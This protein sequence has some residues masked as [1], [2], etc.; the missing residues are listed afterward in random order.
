[1]SETPDPHSLLPLLTALSKSPSTIPATTVTSAITAISQARCSPVQ[2]GALLTALHYTGLDQRAD[3]I[4]GAATAMRGAGVVI[5]GLVA[6]GSDGGEGREG[7]YQGGL[8]DIVGTGGDG[9]N[10]YNVSTTAAVLASGCGVRIAKHGSRASTSSSGSADI[11]TALG[12][13]LTAV[14]APVIAD[15][16]ASPATTGAGKFAFLFAPVFHPAMAHIAPIRKNLGCRTIFNILGPLI[17]PIDYSLPGG[18]EARVLGVGKMSLGPVYADTLRLLGAR[19]ALVVCGEEQL[20]EVSCAGYT[21][22]WRLTDAGTGVETFRVHPTLTFGV[23]THP[24]ESVAGGKGP[25]ENAE[26]FKDLLQGGK[27]GAWPEIADFVAV[28]CAALLVAAGAVEGE[29]EVVEVVD[30]VRTL[31]GERWRRAAERAR[32]AMRTGASWGLWEEFVEVSRKAEEAE[33]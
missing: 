24:L 16:F 3:I 29:E 9:H 31:G 17:S 27:E 4:A 12:A 1:M 7:T 28:N 25:E 15:I 10:T 26:I 14:T 32:E 13:R 19:R 30:G 23:P 5:P 2:T 21:V 22:C 6:Q 11:L 20:D 33:V 18:L 8:V